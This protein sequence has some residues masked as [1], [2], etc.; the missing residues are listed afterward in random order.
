MTI[1]KTKTKEKKPLLCDTFSTNYKGC[2]KFIDTLY[3]ELIVVV[4][5]D[6]RDLT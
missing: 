5:T 1:K 4:S 6:V 3:T 2:M